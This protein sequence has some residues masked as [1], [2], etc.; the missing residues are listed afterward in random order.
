MIFITTLAAHVRAVNRNT[1]ER[2]WRFTTE[3]RIWRGQLSPTGGYSQ[4][5]RM[6]LSTH[7]MN[8]APS[9]CG[10]STLVAMSRFASSL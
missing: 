3:G 10:D 1:G 4:V 6:T 8:E 2:V 5:R 7:W 9:C